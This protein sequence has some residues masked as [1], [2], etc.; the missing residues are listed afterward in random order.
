MSAQA[1]G[2]AG[3]L[4]SGSLQAPSRLTPMEDRLWG[5]GQEGGAELG[6]FQRQ[7]KRRSPGRAHGPVTP[8]FP[9]EDIA[10]PGPGRFSRS[11]RQAE[12]TSWGPEPAESR[13]PGKP[14]PR[15]GPGGRRG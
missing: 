11:H 8:A 7:T 6:S 12:V 9:G 13:G 14:G 3:P 15:A 10:L 4:D 1:G 5:A 2:R